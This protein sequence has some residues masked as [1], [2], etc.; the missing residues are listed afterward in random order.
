MQCYFIDTNPIL[1]FI[2]KDNPEQYKKSE[3]FFISAQK[4]EIE[5][6]FVSEIFIEIEY[7]LRVHYK[8]TR[9]DIGGYLGFILSISSFTI[10]DRLILQKAINT[11]IQ[12]SIDLVDLILF[13]KA[14][15]SN[16]EVFTFDKDFKKLSKSL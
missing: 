7:V 1:R 15:Q 9:A 8:E 2:L 5:I 11:Y 3:Q 4:R 6:V 13:Y 14:Q 12:K 16:A 10:P